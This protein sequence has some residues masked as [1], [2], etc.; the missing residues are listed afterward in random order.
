MR[1][2]FHLIMDTH[3]GFRQAEIAFFTAAFMTIKYIELLKVQGYFLDIPIPS[4]TW[5]HVMLL[6]VATLGHLHPFL[7]EAL[8]QATKLL[9]G[10]HLEMASLP[11]RVGLSN[12]THGTHIIVYNRYDIVCR[13]N[14]VSSIYVY[15]R[16]TL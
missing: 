4:R 3:S 15:V 5:H 14:T 10:W 9:G 13:Y 7:R 12:R 2:Q 8:C 6:Q 16:S 11:N 1:V